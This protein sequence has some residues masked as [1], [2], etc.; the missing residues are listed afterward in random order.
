MSDE[1]AERTAFGTSHAELGA[2]LLGT[3]DCR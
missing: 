1:E 2:C 3:W